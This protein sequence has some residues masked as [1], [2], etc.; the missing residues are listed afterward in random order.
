MSCSNVRG[1]NPKYSKDLMFMGYK[2]GFKA[3]KQDFLSVCQTVQMQK[4]PPPQFCKKVDQISPKTILQI[5]DE[6]KK[7]KTPRCQK[8]RGTPDKKREHGVLARWGQGD[9][10][11]RRE[12]N[13]WG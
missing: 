5:A 10:R 7:G 4:N 1:K 6:L 2:V 13:V 9:L 11:F 8:R 3:Y 12:M